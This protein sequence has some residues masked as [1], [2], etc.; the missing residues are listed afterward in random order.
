MMPSLAGLVRVSAQIAPYS[1]P[2]A[3]VDGTVIVTSAIRS[4][5]TGTSDEPGWMDV[6]LE[7]TFA[8][9]PTAPTND[10]LSIEAAAAYITTWMVEAVELDTC[11]WRWTTVPGVTWSTR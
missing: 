2:G 7:T 8:V 10:P 1:S 11:T 5:R 4:P 6:H 9:R 3:A